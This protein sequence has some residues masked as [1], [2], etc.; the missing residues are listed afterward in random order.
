MEIKYI[1]LFKGMDLTERKLPILIE[2]GKEGDRPVIW[3]CAGI[4]G[5]EVTGIE[6]IHRIF[7]YLKRN[8]LKKGSLFAIPII[9]SAG[10]EMVNRENPY[11]DEDINRNFPGD[12][13]GNTT[14]R[15]A[16]AIFNSITETKPDLVIDLH[17][18]TQNSIAYAIIDRPVSAKIEIKEALEKSWKLVEK[19]G[20]TVTCE[21]GIDLYKKYGLDK[22]LTGALINQ[23]QIPS[24]VVE[25]GGPRVIDEHFARIGMRG[26]RNILNHLQMIEEKEKPWVSETK[27]KTTEKLELIENITS[28]ESGIVDYLIKP[29]Q[30]VKANTPLI[31]I[32]NVLGK[33]EEIINSS[34]DYYI[35]SLNDYSIAFPGSNLLIAAA[36]SS[37]PKEISKKPE[38]KKSDF[39]LNHPVS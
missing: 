11:D 8:P 3:L 36:S 17:A 26:I 4:H 27:I 15:L 29:G 21:G 28:S 1:N 38:E 14:E 25:L 22:S 20:I 6:V 18:D 10:F 35:I 23:N 13:D 19:F 32:T 7:S 37:Q 24:F 31:K 2:R 16:S 9:N 12:P 39:P 33:I 34:R 5:D 30:F